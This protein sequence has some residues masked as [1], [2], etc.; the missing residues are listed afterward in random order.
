[1]KRNHGNET[2]RSNPRRSGHDQADFSL[3]GSEITILLIITH[4]ILSYGHLFNRRTTYIT[5][6]FSSYSHLAKVPNNL[7]IS[8]SVRKVP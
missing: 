6:Q 4:T 3:L 7:W 5:I 8:S 2:P 1:M